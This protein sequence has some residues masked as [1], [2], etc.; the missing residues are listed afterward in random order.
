MDQ[1]RELYRR[2]REKGVRVITADSAYHLPEV[3]HA[4]E[5]IRTRKLGRFISGS[6]INYKNY[7][8][9]GRPQWF[10]RPELAGGGQLI[11][12]GV[13]RIALIRAMVGDGEISV[14]ASVGFFQPHC[15]VEGNGSIFIGYQDGSAVLLE[16]NGYYAGSKEQQ[17]ACHFNFEQGIVNLGGKLSLVF[18]DGTVEY[19]KIPA[20][21]GNSYLPVYRKLL[22]ALAEN[23][24]PYP[25]DREGILDVR[26]ILAAYASAREGKEVRLDSPAWRFP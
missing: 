4:K 21:K 5:L 25:S 24:Q 7:F 8:T 10:L 14:K 23:K 18:R 17:S 3:V 20:Q 16:E 12:V 6:F 22:S 19:P 2:A 1:C 9:P 26:I 15:S 13:H 11:N